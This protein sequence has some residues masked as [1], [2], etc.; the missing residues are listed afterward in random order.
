MHS[1][2]ITGGGMERLSDPATRKE[3]KHWARTTTSTTL[4]IAT[5]T[6]A[7]STTLPITTSTTVTAACSD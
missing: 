1:A 2:I 6:I 3:C 5:I 4:P 7:T